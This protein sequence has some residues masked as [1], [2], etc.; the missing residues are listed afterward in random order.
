ME[1]R[2]TSV[3]LR[4]INLLTAA[5]IAAALAGEDEVLDGG[6]E[7]VVGNDFPNQYTPV[8]DGYFYAKDL[9]GS[10][11]RVELYFTS[12]TGLAKDS[13]IVVSGIHDLIHSG[14][15]RE[16]EISGSDGYKT[17]SVDTPPWD[18]RSS[19]AGTRNTPDSSITHTALFNPRSGSDFGAAKQLI[20][21]RKIASVSATTTTATVTFTSN[22]YFEV[23]DAVYVDM[24]S[25][26]PYYG[27]DGLYRVKSVGSNFITFDFSTALD[28]PINSAAVSEDRYVH[29]VARSYTR[30]GAT[31]IDTSTT[32]DTVYVWKDLR[33]VTYSTGSVTKDEVAPSPIENLEATDEDET[34]AGAAVP[35]RKVTL[36]WSPPTTNADGTPLDDLVGYTIWWK[37]LAGQPAWEKADS[38]GAET[39]FSKGNFLQGK[40]AFF[41]VFARDAG[42]NLSDPVSITH[43][44]GVSTPTVQ[45]PK[46]PTV[47]TYLGTIKI[48][49]DDLTEAGL[50]QADTAK[51][52]EVFF[53]PIS[54]FTPGETNYYGKFPANAGSYIIIPGTELVDNTDYYIKIRVRDVYNNI[55]EPSTQVAIRA[56]IKNIVTF[57]MID[58]GTLNGEVIIGAD[59]RT[60]DNP[61]VNGGII[62]NK[63]GITAYDSG[64]NQ[65][66][67]LD[68]TDGAV[69][70]GEY[71]KDSDAAGIYLAS[72]VADGKFAA[73]PS[74]GTFIT[75][76][77]AGQV[78]LSQTSASSTYVTQLDAGRLY[79][80]KG[81]AAGDING[82]STTIDGG[83]ITTNSLNASKIVS[84]SI[85][86]TQIATDAITSAKIQAGAVT[87]S[88]IVATGIFGRTIG[89]ATTGKRIILSSDGENHLKFNSATDTT[90]GQIVSTGTDIFFNK[91]S[92]SSSGGVR[93][94]SSSALLSAGA[95][96]AGFCGALTGYVQ[97][98]DGIVRV[99][100]DSG[101]GALY[102]SF[103]TQDFSGADRYM[104]IDSA[105]KVKYVSNLPGI[106]SDI[107]LKNLTEDAPLGLNFISKLNPV[108]FT[109][110]PETKIAGPNVKQFGLVAQELE[111]ALLDS[112]IAIADQELVTGYGD[113]SYVDT[114]A[115]GESKEQMRK[116]NYMSLV[117]IL[118]KSTQELAAE[119]D[120]LKS[121]IR[122]LKEG[123]TNGS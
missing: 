108:S 119:I 72:N 79:L 90:T 121:E 87:A 123:T 7:T 78:Y 20:V 61:S 97:V 4:P 44:T 19:Y 18:N 48:A 122:T 109:W 11:S 35:R 80:N 12:D 31:F 74:E 104:I 51:E 25:D 77:T 24:P 116:I 91:S 37:E 118:V 46:A 28:E 56:K 88:E 111:Q 114:L 13:T 59:I 83:K 107:R 68:A 52:I 60:S 62:S 53:S 21:K 117:P 27:L 81:G 103:P 82:N 30:D 58:V 15:T 26:T 34:A 93:L 16:L 94:T 5:Q 76:I 29:A 45:T 113:D 23:G 84:G 64:G 85:S 55:T 112:G 92:G 89:T 69:Y 115:E 70:I 22:N 110:K 99:G 2:V 3:E 50:V 75:D 54:G 100:R 8:V 39:N 105:G 106:L 43:T 1:G 38:T 65:T 9:T 57:D 86:A 73:K 95:Q 101:S 6:P 98:S 32:P 33:W 14:G 36:T 102:L 63:Q 96:G 47:T 71:L 17:I 66:F 120:L 40:P 42:G 10:G 67:R 49:Y 41:R